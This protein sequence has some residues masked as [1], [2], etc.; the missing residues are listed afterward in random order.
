MI[1]LYN[2]SED[3]V[4]PTKNFHI[5][6]PSQDTFDPRELCPNIQKEINRNITKLD[7]KYQLEM[8]TL[9]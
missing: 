8:E 5:L 9:K 2:T 4:I 1:G 7:D 6:I 3:E